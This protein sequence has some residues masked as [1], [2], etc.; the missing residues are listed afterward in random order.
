M[1]FF[2]LPLIHTKLYKNPRLGEYPCEHSLLCLELTQTVE[3]KN[4]CVTV[5]MQLKMTTA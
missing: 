2:S 1:F 4:A 3:E 5:S